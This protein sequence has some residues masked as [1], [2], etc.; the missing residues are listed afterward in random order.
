MRYIDTNIVVRLI[1][2]D[3]ERQFGIARRELDLGDLVLS[4]A[5]IVETEWVLR[6]G[7]RWTRRVI[8]QALRAFTSLGAIHIEDEAGLSA[9]LDDHEHGMDLA[10]ALHLLD[11][12]RGRAE[13]FL[14]FDS[15][16]ARRAHSS[17][18]TVTLLR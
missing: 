17:E 7:Y 2:E 16:L 15:D 6:G 9:I 1:T 8:N 10:D 12:Q 3:D 11:A 14:T 4:L 5:V 18:L 13:A